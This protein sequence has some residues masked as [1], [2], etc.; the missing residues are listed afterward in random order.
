MGRIISLDIIRG[1]AIAMVIG[2]HGVVSISGRLENISPLFMCFFNAITPFRMPVLMLL[3]GLFLWKSLS[4]GFYPFVLGKIYHILYPYIIWSFIMWLIMYIRSR[5]MSEEGY[6]LAYSLMVS[7]I[8]HLWFLHSLIIFFAISV[9]FFIPYKS[10][11]CILIALF[12]EFCSDE[13]LRFRI[14]LF[15]LIII[16]GFLGGHIEV[17]TKL[18]FKSPVT[19]VCCGV[20]GILCFQK[21]LPDL[22]NEI[23]LP[24]TIFPFLFSFS[25]IGF[26]VR[27]TGYIQWLGRKS[28]GFYLSH[29]PIQMLLVQCLKKLD[30]S[31]DCKVILNILLGFLFSTLFVYI[32]ERYKI[33]NKIFIDPTCK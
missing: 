3:S 1:V 22:F 13:Y 17:L 24:L 27:V 10:F 16:G 12:M 25:N 11:F 29:L 6:S 18:T 9:I 20:F 28:L 32:C 26:I 19:I 23:I 14:D 33:I 8:E 4:K 15:V 21:N 5:V 31:D 7:P 2:L 30:M